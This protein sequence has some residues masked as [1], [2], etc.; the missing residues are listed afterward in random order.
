[1]VSGNGE[2][3]IDEALH[4][5]N[6]GGV[7]NRTDGVTGLITIFKH[8]RQTSSLEV[9]KDGA[10][11]TIYEALFKVATEEKRLYLSAKN[12]K[13]R[14]KAE[15]TL[16]SCSEALRITIKAGAEKL[17]PRT[18]IAVI[19]HITQLLPVASG[20]Y[21]LAFSQQYLKVLNILLG[22][23]AHVELLDQGDWLATVEFCLDGIEQYES[24]T[25]A[26]SIPHG[27][28][29]TVP[30]STA[31]SVYTSRSR[32][33]VKSV[34]G[35]AHLSSIKK[36]NSE[37]LMECLLSLVSA[38]NAAVSERTEH[39]L[40]AIVHFL[41][42]Q[43]NVVSSFH[44]IAFAALNAVLSVTG[45]DEISLAESVVCSVVPCISRLWSSKTA[46]N[47]E[48]LNTAKDEMAITIL[49]LRL[50]LEKLV[51]DPLGDD[52]LGNIL[53]DLRDSLANDYEKR[54]ERDQLQLDD[55]DFSIDPSEN[56]ISSSLSCGYL[57][58]RQQAPRAERKWA[59]VQVLAILDRLLHGAP[60]R[61]NPVA[62]D[63]NE[64]PEGASHPRKRRRI[65]E[66]FDALADEIRLGDSGVQLVALQ[67]LSFAL[68]PSQVSQNTLAGILAT[69]ASLVLDRNINISC[70]A[71]LCIS[72]CAR[73]SAA[74]S[75]TAS[76]SW[77]QL[78]HTVSRLVT[79]RA[80][81]RPACY[82][83][84]TILA[85]KLVE[86]NDVVEWATSMLTMTEI[87][88]P[89][90][91]C[92]SSLALM[93]HLVH[94]RNMEGSGGGVNPS[95]NVVRWLFSKWNPAEK[96]FATR[97]SIDIYPVDVSNLL[98]TIFDLP[99]LALFANGNQ[100][101]GVISQAWL[102]HRQNEK[103]LRL[104]LL[105]DDEPRTSTECSRCAPTFRLYQC[106]QSSD[107][108][109]HGNP[110][111][112]LISDLLLPKLDVLAQGWGEQEASETI[113][114]S[115]DSMH[116][117]L[118]A[119]ITTCLI[120]PILENAGSSYM[121]DDIKRI[122]ERLETIITSVNSQVGVNR[123]V[124][125][126]MLQAIRPYLPAIG[127]EE[128]CHIYKTL[129]RLGNF[130]VSFAEIFKLYKCQ[131][132]DGFAADDMELDDVFDTQQ[133]WTR[134]KRSQNVIERRE[135]AMK[136]SPATFFNNTSTKLILAASFFE[137]QTETLCV[138]TNFID[139]LLNLPPM[140]IVS[141]TELIC[142]ILHS[143]L[144]LS[145]D[146]ASRIVQCAGGLLSSQY[147]CCEVTLGLCID[148]MEG[149]LSS[150]A[151]SKSG[152]LGEM[153]QQLYGWLVGTI[154]SKRG[155]S[156]YVQIR[157]SKLL[158]Q[159]IRIQPT[160]GD[161]QSLPS[162][163]SSL[164]DIL[165]KAPILVKFNL[166]QN[167]PDIFGLFVL[168]NHLR[169]LNDLLDSLPTDLDWCEG[170]AFRLY[171]LS[172]LASRWP[173]LLRICAYYILEVSGRVPASIPYA[174][175]CLLE[176]SE[177][178]GLSS[179]RELFL[180]FN[181]QL[182]FTWL[183]TE[184][185]E[186]LPHIIFGYN[187][188][189]D[190]LRDSQEEISAL[191]V[192]RD[193]DDEVKSLA[194]LLEEPVEQILMKSFT[195]VIAYSVAHDISIP[196]SDTSGKYI[197]GEARVRKQL[198]K[199]VFLDL[200]KT[201]FADIISLLFK[202]IDHEQDLEKSFMKEDA[203]QIPA[204][205]LSEIKEF[206]SSSITLPPSQQ[207]TF[208]AKYLTREINHV[209]GRTPYEPSDIFTPVMVTFVAR[210][211]LD[212]MNPALGSLHACSV[213]RRLRVLIGLAGP[214]A[215][216]GYPLEMILHNLR[217]LLADV[218]CADDAIGIAQYLFT[219]GSEY[220][221]TV[222]SFIITIALSMFGTLK[223]FLSSSP[224]STTQESQYRETLSKAES[225]H[226]WLGLYLKNYKVIGLDRRDQDAFRAMVESAH[227]LSA[228]DS[229]DMGTTG[230][231]LL[232][233]ILRDKRS[234]RNLLSKSTCDVVFS[235][236]Y[237]EF[238]APASFRTD[239]LGQDDRAVRYAPT[240]WELCKTGSTSSSFLTWAGRVF[241][242]A[243]AATGH[244]ELSLLKET[245][246]HEILDPVEIDASNKPSSRSSILGLVKNLTVVDH[247]SVTGVAEAALRIIVSG[248]T[249]QPNNA[250]DAACSISLSASLIQCST[251]SPYNVSPADML[252]FQTPAPKDPFSPGCIEDPAC[253]RDLSIFLVQSVPSDSVIHPIQQL[254]VD[255]AGFA[256]KCFP[257]ILHIVLSQKLDESQ[258]MKRLLSTALRSW[259]SNGR[260]IV[261]ERL[262]L[263]INAILYLR[264]QA[265]PRETSIADRSQWLDIDYR[266]ASQ[267]AVNCGMLKTALLFTE[268]SSSELVKA[269]RRFS[270]VK[271]PESEILFSI[272]KNLDDPDIFYGLQPTATLETISARM[273]YEK[274][275]LRT[276]MFRGAEYD[277]QM[278]KG[279][280]AS[281]SEAQSLVG[282]LSMLD[283]D[284]LS[285]SL[286]QSQ[287]MAVVMN[288]PA[289]QNMFRTARKLEQWDLPI[290]DAYDGGSITIYKTFQAL[291]NAVDHVSAHVAVDT[292]IK[293]VMSNLNQVQGDAASIHTSL[294][295]LSIFTEM[296][297][298]LS[299]S[300]SE[301]FEDM[302]QR[303]ESRSK[304]MK[305]GKFEDVSQIISSRQTL[306]SCV[307]QQ[308]SLRKM[309][310]VSASDTR[311]VEARS[312]LLSSSIHRSHGALQESL[313]SATYL[314][315]ITGSCQELGLNIE[316]AAYFEVANA[317][318]DQ[319]EMASSIGMLQELEQL[320]NLREQTIP[321]GKSKILAK[322]ASQVSMAKL[323]K[324]DRIIEKYLSPALAELKG[325]TDGSDAG[326]VYHE[327]AVF[328]DRQYQDP[329][330]IEDLER[331]RTLK[332]MKEMEVET[333]LKL[334]KE[335]TS[336]QKQRNHRA[337]NQAKQWLALDTEEYERLNDGR[338]QLLRRS[339]ENYLLSLAA[340]DDH[341][342]DALR[343]TALWLEHSDEE[344][345]SES[346]S[347]YLSNVATMKFASLANQLT[348]RLLDTKDKF[349]VQLLNLVLNICKDH[350]HH[351]M[352]QIWAGTNSNPS[353]NDETALSR[354]K[355]TKEVALKLSK[356]A[357]SGGTWSAIDRISHQYCHFA[358]EREKVKS[359]SKIS[360]R[361]SPAGSALNAMLPKNPLPPPTLQIELAADKNYSR[362]P[363][364]ISV[365]PSFSIASGV[366][367]P[368]I[369][370]LLASNGKRYRQLVKG[371]A[372]D[373][374][375]DAIMEQ[376]F[377]Q[378]S[379]LLKENSATRQRNLGIRTYKV[380][381]LS[382]TAGIIEFVP[383]TMP[384]HEFLMPAHERFYPKDLRSQQC[385]SEIQSV[386]TQKLDVRVKKYLAVTDKFHPVLRY[387]HLEKFT[388]PDEWFARRLAYTRSTAA[389]SILG[390]V[391]G[392]GDRHG[393]NILLDE[394]TG[395]V[396]H[397]DL[398]VAF[399]MGRVLPVPELV[400]FRLTRDIVDGMGISKTEGVYRRCCEFT[401]EALRKE[402]DTI[403]TILDVLRYD[404]LYTWSISP[405]RLAKLQDAQSAAPPISTA[406]S[407]ATNNGKSKGAVNEPSEADR[408]LTVVRKKLSKTLSVTAT[409]NDLINQ[410]TDERNLAVLFAG[411]AA[412]A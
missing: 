180:L 364:M 102:R 318:W 198:G 255:A 295:A 22:H 212:T 181:S 321:I 232:M 186:S 326:Q 270:S 340:W 286:L 58:L 6:S 149:L 111:K 403:M 199:N 62:T 160:Y 50:H 394:K 25:R 366:S 306:L 313:T 14:T 100:P 3:R 123:V 167:I 225:F 194:E 48:M 210:K 4:T 10:Y 246:L 156:P 177:T 135:M 11:H 57:R 398:G 244:I 155:T 88:A 178:L 67:T 391:L 252:A 408:A 342:N 245:D 322:I 16:S 367:A 349:Q 214:N 304:W 18:V 219:R 136:L 41:N 158:F 76:F 29:I 168:K 21:C 293:S 119:C 327:F 317:M 262:K 277:T 174:K 263:L 134:S 82:L 133:G 72:S 234:R 227:G 90:S 81:C 129:P 386:Q 162:V 98:R 341:N 36:R 292:G 229:T 114:I 370:T 257:F 183:D 45:A 143:D 140:D 105:L 315:S 103:T 205:I 350:P 1:M 185:F 69:L 115:S 405:I 169:I 379:E 203:L 30:L 392:L 382:S 17:K 400:P 126:A 352:Y 170:N 282:A 101:G 358:S 9:L 122:L 172:R 380:L 109:L 127:S 193:R 329:D 222:P 237:S 8:N 343:F 157:F 195:K 289:I 95:Q 42:S 241:G 173:T 217:P 55:M 12:D 44:Q 110:M 319:G 75:S 325:K 396:V 107:A 93:A 63:D 187:T 74:E 362:L 231:D 303:F 56:R 305:T 94:M 351:G 84:H 77:K 154:I 54:A 404:P 369:V 279:G 381:P 31:S 302:L 200:M 310:N 176:V 118:S 300:N 356:S 278:R 49:L 51:S 24:S 290:P 120:L 53:K 335:A 388:D 151:N 288:E 192:M 309:I 117:T 37:E 197:T 152:E 258:T 275:G 7:R 26:A 377:A 387:F 260:D 171:I 153:V 323:E 247:G 233:D 19:E 332:E 311:L 112:R 202:L 267:A 236:L 207:P 78:W 43:G 228:S 96:A 20:E 97:T 13:A 336:G 40:K 141:C 363:T 218:E 235:L 27:N 355:A 221:S 159:L 284:G 70:W 383:N 150:W 312:S 138:P 401:L 281:T 412:Y 23:E 361:N 224:S 344:V 131:K 301:Q 113:E 249:S 175:R 395:E 285:Y 46:A 265:L 28:S 165:Q 108:Q 99:G 38:P 226:S 266:Q 130:I 338:G 269:S 354:Q 33:S 128:I 86:Y 189:H 251:W 71:I 137:C 378:V 39:I 89:A 208:K 328:C 144:S 272:F 35:E 32:S 240:V 376:V 132:E 273:E 52:S 308:S 330:S 47:D 261:K 145:S 307:N 60:L 271:Q 66:R 291:N 346:V 320:S 239:H 211:L 390:Y 397:I 393:H 116:S 184:P 87:S 68:P 372:D 248:V 146:D 298:V 299:S 353:A 125:E 324:P 220:L 254:L 91:I 121:L 339:L 196:P 399:E 242:R 374:R 163:R 5:M 345:I 360:L 406:S 296:D 142:E 188:L 334:S 223:V 264:T 259:F 371:G 250:D 209:C 238:A 80:L 139:Y 243:F 83:L 161:D 407:T 368:K 230:G 2:I 409:V 347:K 283:L 331:L 73:Q 314:N 411:W 373:L 64:S 106:A 316:A 104:L 402:A 191:M 204:S 297:E 65:T 333:L 179:A 348:S 213:L 410:A 190:L 164:F 280:Q 206:S 294:Q 287:Q 385:R 79:S 337:Y 357:R 215:V 375:Q 61:S 274:D 268:L 216:S 92:D 359:G 148:T 384:L 15:K 365:D 201:H 124:V 389:I 147:S 182:L 85:K 276:L 59:V 34:S 166:A 256:E 253:I